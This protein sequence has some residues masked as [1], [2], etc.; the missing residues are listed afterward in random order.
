MGIDYKKGSR[1]WDDESKRLELFQEE[2][3][4][5]KNAGGLQK[6][7]KATEQDSPLSP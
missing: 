3:M 6:L 7:V 1:G 4:S 5:Q 2:V